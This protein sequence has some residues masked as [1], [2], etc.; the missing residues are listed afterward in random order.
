MEKRINRLLLLMGFVT[1]VLSLLLSTTIFL[2]VYEKQVKESLRTD[3]KLIVSTYTGANEFSFLDSIENASLRVT[4]VNRDGTVIKDTAKQE[5][6]ADHS[7]RPEIRKAFEEGYAE[8]D[9]FSDTLGEKTYYAAQRIREDLVIRCSVPEKV[10]YEYLFSASV[11]LLIIFI[12]VLLLS[13]WLSSMLTERLIA[14]IRSVASDPDNPKWQTDE[15]RE[16]YPELIPVVEELCSKRKELQLKAKEIEAEHRRLTTV[17]EHMEEGL[18]L[19]DTNGYILSVNSSACMYLHMSK[20]YIGKRFR[21]I[22]SDERI[23]TA[24]HNAFNSDREAFDVA[25]DGRTVRFLIEPVLEKKAVLGVVCLMM[26]ITERREMERMKQEFTANVS[27]ELKTPLTSISGYAEMME[28]GMVKPE[29]IPRFSAMIRTE[30]ARLLLLIADII[31]LSEM[32][33]KGMQLHKQTMDLYAVAQ[34][35]VRQLETLAARQQ[36][37]LRLEGLHS[38]MDADPSMVSQLCYNLIDNAI[39]YNCK[40]GE[41]CVTVGEKQIAV[42]DTGIGIPA[43][44]LSQVFERFYR[45]D[46][47][48]SKETGGTGLGLAIVKR[49]AD[50]HGATVHLESKEQTGTTVTVVFP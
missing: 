19:L 46:K 26:D 50:A 14:P 25:I 24:V 35:C 40:G 15:H 7:D 33:E 22:Y 20:P 32:E 36:I 5:N 31:S 27:H 47:S 45:V 39:R 28:N 49:I 38:E 3:L 41:V 16:V 48:R 23:L 18:L 2:Q 8:G 17:L 43:E 4:I 30:A 34:L 29:D 6:D 10:I 12:I 21:D 42:A 11:Y 37:T 44:H 9:R 1:A 13:I